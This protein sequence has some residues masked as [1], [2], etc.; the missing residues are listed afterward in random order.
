MAEFSATLPYYDEHKHRRFAQMFV[1]SQTVAVL[2]GT[3]QVNDQLVRKV[4]TGP[5]GLATR[6]L[7]FPSSVGTIRLASGDARYFSVESMN[8]RSYLIDRQTHATVVC[9]ITSLNFRAAARESR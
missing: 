5:T 4:W 2:V 7:T 1:F 3:S 6:I 9:L 8:Q